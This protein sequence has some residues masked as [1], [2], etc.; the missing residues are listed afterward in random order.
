MGEKIRN[1]FY[2]GLLAITFGQRAC[3]VKHTRTA[4]VAGLEGDF[5]NDIRRPRLHNE[6]YYGE[7]ASASEAL[8]S[9][10]RKHSPDTFLARFVAPFLN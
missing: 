4:Y 7:G 2:A 8:Q 1:S 9:Y 5:S 6:G 3:V 10:Y